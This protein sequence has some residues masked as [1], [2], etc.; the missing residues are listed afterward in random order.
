MVITYLG[1]GGS[2]IQA[3]WIPTHCCKSDASAWFHASHPRIKAGSAAHPSEHYS[4]PSTA[5]A[6]SGGLVS[7]P[8]RRRSECKMELCADRSTSR[9]ACEV[10]R[11]RGLFAK[12]A[13]ALKCERN[14]ARPYGPL[15]N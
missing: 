8:R 11:R 10:E 2:V 5:R 7:K 13:E 1:A 3:G 9:V 15:A 14:G 6:E 12:H 4:K